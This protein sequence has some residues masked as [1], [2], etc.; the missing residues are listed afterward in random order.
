MGFAKALLRLSLGGL[1]KWLWNVKE[2]LEKAPSIGN[3]LKRFT[4]KSEKSEKCKGEKYEKFDMAN[5]LSKQFFTKRGDS[6]QSAINN[7]NFTTRDC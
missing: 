6:Y 3:F 7:R 2:I 4:E 1:F 5:F